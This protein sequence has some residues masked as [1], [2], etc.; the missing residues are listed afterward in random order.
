MG[1][2]CNK[3]FKYIQIHKNVAH[4]AIKCVYY[5]SR[6]SH[7]T[8]VESTCT[9]MFQHDHHTTGNFKT[10]H[11]FKLIATVQSPYFCA[12]EPDSFS[13]VQFT[14]LHHEHTNSRPQPSE[15]THVASCFL[16]RNAGVEQRK[17]EKLRCPHLVL[18]RIHIQPSQSKVLG[19]QVPK[20]LL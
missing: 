13:A 11:N 12:F 17:V 1:N 6:C 9:T 5:S 16:F 18:D 20:T 7:Y 2:H 8:E 15:A 10:W 14:E 3:S 19:P 4:H